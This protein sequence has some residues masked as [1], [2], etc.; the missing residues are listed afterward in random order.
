MLNK[1]V[2][3]SFSDSKI[4]GND[5][6]VITFIVIKLPNRDFCVSNPNIGRTIWTQMWQIVRYFV[7]EWFQS[8]R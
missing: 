4:T 8:I 1:M 7:A 5:L 2:H 6:V 3:K